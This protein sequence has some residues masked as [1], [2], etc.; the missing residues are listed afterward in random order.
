MPLTDDDRERWIAILDGLPADQTP[1]PGDRIANEANISAF[2]GSMWLNSSLPE[3]QGV[4]VPELQLI[5]VQY[6]VNRA[7]AYAAASLAVLADLADSP[8]GRRVAAKGLERLGRLGIPAPDWYGEELVLDGSWEPGDVYGDSRTY[9]LSF[10]APSG[11]FG[12][13]YTVDYSDFHS[14]MVVACGHH[15]D[16]EALLRPHVQRNSV[17]TDRLFPPRPCEPAEVVEGTARSLKEWDVFSVGGDPANLDFTFISVRA[18][19]KARLRM[20]PQ[21][22]DRSTA[23]VP[24]T[25]EEQARRNGA[26]LTYAMTAGRELEE[27]HLK[28]IDE[29]CWFHGCN[30]FSVS[31][32]SSYVFL[33]RYLPGKYEPRDPVVRAVKE[34]MPDFVTW[35][36]NITDVP[37][38]AVPHL[39][40]KTAQYLKGYPKWKAMD[41]AVDRIPRPRSL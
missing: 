13:S 30:G 22:E 10:R 33:E 15:P 4:S 28:A 11:D 8:G 6:Y 27:P 16:I 18:L 20:L 3:V 7:D 38:E 23:P 5:A 35:A 19:W 29:L 21:T 37:L 12:L 1:D 17:F 25:D 9:F 14:D 34:L 36:A 41:P 26:F 24:P 32:V 40:H 31:P 2:L 39:E